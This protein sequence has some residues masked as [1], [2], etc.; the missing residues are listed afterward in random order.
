VK[1]AII[2]SRG[3]PAKYGGFETIAEELAERLTKLGH[4][5]TVT[6]ERRPDDSVANESYKGV[7]LCFS[8][9][10]SPGTYGVRKFYE[11]FNDLY[12][13]LKLARGVDILYLLGYSA[14]ILQF[15]PRLLSEGTAFIVNIDGV[16]WKRRK[17]NLFEKALVRLSL[18]GATTFSDI[19]AVDARSMV[20]YVGSPAKDKVVYAPNGVSKPGIVP[21]DYGK[22]AAHPNLNRSV[23]KLMPGEYWLAVAR[24]EPENNIDL[25]IEGFSKSCTRKP[26]IVVGDFTSPR[27]RKRILNTLR[28]SGGKPV[29]FAGSIY[30]LTVL[31]MLRQNAFGYIH[32][33]SVGGTNPSLLEAMSM[34][35]LVVAHDNEFN[36]EVCSDCALYFRNADELAS[37]I[38]AAESDPGAFSDLRFKAERRALDEYSWDHVL[39]QYD[40]LFALAIERSRIASRALRR[41]RKST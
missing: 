38:N 13:V 18:W 11:V 21:W 32:G 28:K 5:V 2:G 3:I 24:L 27:Y 37:R 20:S 7:E 8:P 16:E 22:I 35:N 30:N 39:S 15:V 25:V 26:L 4:R 41:T 19:V 36:R 14:G 34:A 10:R 17:F 33:H 29:V 1:I 9:F 6:C 12:F 40:P 23:T 31:N